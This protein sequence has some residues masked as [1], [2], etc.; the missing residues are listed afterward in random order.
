MR[1]SVHLATLGRFHR[2]CVPH[3]KGA[4]MDCSLGFGDACLDF[5]AV[6]LQN[7]FSVKRHP[8][9]ISV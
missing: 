4:E 1:R 6:W 3:F 9:L 8:I 7:G 2:S 5:P